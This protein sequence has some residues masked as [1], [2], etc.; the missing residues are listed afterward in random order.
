[1]ITPLLFFRHSLVAKNIN[2]KSAILS[3]RILLFFLFLNHNL[4]GQTINGKVLDAN[5]LSTAPYSTLEIKGKGIGWVSDSMG[6]FS[7]EIPKDII[8]ENDTLLIRSLGF[9]SAEVVLKNILNITTIE[10]KL[11][12]SIFQLDSIVIKPKNSSFIK[13]V[14]LE[15]TQ[16]NYRI[17]DYSQ[18]AV[19]MDNDDGLK[20]VIQNVSF[21]ISREGKP[22]APFRIRFY[23]LQEDGSPGR[24][25]TKENI[26][27]TPKK[28]NAW[29][30]VDVS[31]YKILVPKEGYFVAMEWIFTDKKYYFDTLIH[32][33]NLRSYGQI[34]GKILNEKIT[35]NSWVYT[36]GYGW[37]KHDAPSKYQSQGK[38][39]FYNAMINSEIKPIE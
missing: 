14:T 25:V 5:T 39:T 20:A 4:L 34:L 35:P 11:K 1:M 23:E 19:Y 31:K 8:S 21:F 17:K 16:V 37:L 26:I 29:F 30:K 2:V 27:V 6:S 9:N 32:G 28:G 13:G 36:L 33:E 15:K 12:P 22:E 18:I 3:V 10:F 38:T 7:L 24:D